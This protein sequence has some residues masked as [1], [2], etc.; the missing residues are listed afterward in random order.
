LGDVL[1]VA[2]TLLFT[3]FSAMGQMLAI[4]PA[5]DLALQNTVQAFLDDKLTTNQLEAELRDYIQQFEAKPYKVRSMNIDWQKV[6]Q[7]RMFALAKVSFRITQLPTAA[8]FKGEL[9]AAQAAV[10]IAPF[11]LMWRGYGLDPENA[12]S[13]SRRRTDQLLEEIG[14]FAGID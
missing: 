14:A 2:V 4:D 10:K 12:D 7:E 5:R 13:L 8:F 1:I 11:F 6:P 3:S 9:T